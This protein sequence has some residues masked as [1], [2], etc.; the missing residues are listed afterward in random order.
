MVGWSLV[1]ALGW[2]SVGW[3]LVIGWRVGRW[4]VVGGRLV[5]GFKKTHI[6]VVGTDH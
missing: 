3:W 1:S 4:L 6:S 2:W 5:T